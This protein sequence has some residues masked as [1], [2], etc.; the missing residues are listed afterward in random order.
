MGIGAVAVFWSTI[1]GFLGGVFLRSVISFGWEGLVFAVVLAIGIVLTTR[2]QKGLIIACFICAFGCGAARMELAIP[3]RDASLDTK[4]GSKV[5]VEGIVFE[6]PDERESSTRLAVRTTDG[7]GFVVVAPLHAG[8]QYGDHVKAEGKLGV[9]EKF[10]TGSGREFDYPGYLAKDGILYT[11]SFAHVKKTTEYKGRSFIFFLKKASIWIKRQ[12]LNGLALALP[13]PAAGLAGGITVGDKRGVGED[14]GQVFRTVGL[15]HVI[16]LSGYNITIVIYAFSWILARMRSPRAA[17]FGVS[18][19]VAIFFAL[20]TGLAAASVRA[21]M[22]AIIASVGA[23]TGRVYLASR[24]L[25]FVA[26]VMVLWNPYV[27]AFDPGFQL[28]ILATAGLIMFSGPIASRVSFITERFGLR[29][30]M[31]ATLSTQLTVLPL[32]LFQ[33]GQFNLFALPVNLLTLVVIPW[34]M[35]FSTIA[36]VFGLFTGALAPI[37]GLPAF[38][39]LSYVIAVAQFFAGLP[40][41]TVTVPAFGVGILLVT[42]AL[43]C[44]SYWVIAKPQSAPPPSSN[45]NS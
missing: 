23:I 31:S 35:L 9:P 34:A 33:N 26:A 21:A 28:S 18:V 40:F 36:A 16:V 2:S 15:T 10:E 39:L 44:I 29:E 11:L 25:A 42:Y 45:S 4:I 13:E 24:A 8:I 7:A 19:F 37:F 27:L 30:I 32:L 3:D 41:A 6:E 1:G 12:Y 5:V 20:I 22:M 38:A 17:E 14:L 43:L